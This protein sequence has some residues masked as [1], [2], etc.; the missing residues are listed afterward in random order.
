MR[1]SILI[2]I[3][4]VS[5][6]CYYYYRR[7]LEKFDNLT[8]DSCNVLSNRYD[9][10][11]SNTAKNVLDN[12][13]IKEFKPVLDTEVLEDN[14]EMC[15]MNNDAKS[16]MKDVFMVD[17]ECS[18]NDPYFNSFDFITDVQPSEKILGTKYDKFDRCVL[19]IDKSKIDN[20]SLDRFWKTWGEETDIC[21]RT[22]KSIKERNTVLKQKQKD[23]LSIYNKNEMIKMDLNMLITS[24]NKSMYD[25]KNQI[26]ELHIKLQKTNE[27][28]T[29]KAKMIGEGE[30]TYS[31]LVDSSNRQLNNL[32][33]KK[34]ELE[35]AISLIR[36][37]FTKTKEAAETLY[38][39]I[40]NLNDKIRPLKEEYNKVIKKVAEISSKREQAFKEIQLKEEEKAVLL[41]TTAQKQNDLANCERIQRELKDQ[42]DALSIELDNCIKEII[43]LEKRLQRCRLET[44]NREQEYNVLNATYNKLKTLLNESKRIYNKVVNDTNIETSKFEETKKQYPYTSCIEFYEKSRIAKDTIAKC[45]ADTANL[46]KKIDMIQNVLDKN[47]NALEACDKHT[48]ELMIYRYIISPHYVKNPN[49]KSCDNLCANIYGRKGEAMRYNETIKSCECVYIGSKSQSKLTR[50]NND[51]IINSMRSGGIKKDFDAKCQRYD[52]GGIGCIF[53]DRWGNNP[54][55]MVLN[56]VCH[57][58]NTISIRDN[59]LVC[60]QS[61]C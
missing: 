40:K 32:N 5:L 11:Y 14:V 39:D 23:L 55:Q 46:D 47:D 50:I 43:D 26:E 41:A 44:S 56:E 27:D 9:G 18:K 38:N 57:P 51:D 35:K 48:Q 45:D 1:Y 28:Y 17:K 10:E 25:L 60:I 61:S 6:L 2:V 15:Y 49:C 29:E 54:Y 37:T 53:A 13:R 21:D 52:N 58:N 36:P 7:R 24:R 19:K 20:D 30:K 8:V 12:N 22:T 42:R 16:G 3:A 4:I 31:S 59:K 34:A 33:N